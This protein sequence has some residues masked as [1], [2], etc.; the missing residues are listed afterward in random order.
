MIT[1]QQK[2][3]KNVLLYRYDSKKRYTHYPAL[4]KVDSLEFGTVPGET[5]D[6]PVG[7]LSAALAEK[8]PE[9]GTAPG[10]CLDSLIRQQFA[11]RQIDVGEKSAA[12]RQILERQIRDLGTGV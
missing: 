6:R 10:Q 9:L 2:I 12:V 11:P 5:L 8:A 3:D 7:Q 1:N 4:V